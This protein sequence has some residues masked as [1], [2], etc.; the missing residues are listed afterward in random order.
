[1]KGFTHDESAE[2][3]ISYSKV[4]G[5][6]DDLP[7]VSTFTQ[8]AWNASMLTQKLSAACDEGL[9]QDGARAWRTLYLVLP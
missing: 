5:S 2:A 8:A 3:E 6:P 7:V 9:T 4:Q 1:M